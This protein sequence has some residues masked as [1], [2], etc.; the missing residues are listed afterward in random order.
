MLRVFWAIS[1]VSATV[2]WAQ[3][4]KA[5]VYV[6]HDFTAPTTGTLATVAP[7]TDELG[8]GWLG[9]AANFAFTAGNQGLEC[10]ATGNNQASM[11]ETNGREDVEVT[12][13][14]TINKGDIN[15]NWQGV[16]LRGSV[17]DESG[18]IARFSGPATDPDLLL[19][20]GKD[21]LL[22][23]WD[24]SALLTTQPLSGDTVKLV[25]RCE[26]DAITFQSIQVNAGSVET[27]ASAYTLLGTSQI[28]HGAGSG[29]DRYGLLNKERLAS[30]VERYTY[31]K[32]ASIPTGPASYNSYIALDGVDDYISTPDS[33]TN[34]VTGD[35]DI[36]A[37]VA[38]D[39]ST[40]GDEII[41]GKDV[42]TGNQRSI[43]LYVSSTKKLGLQPSQDGSG[44]FAEVSSVALDVA[45]NEELWIRGT[46]DFA[47]GNVTFYTATDEG[48]PSS[49]SQLGAVQNT[50]LTAIYDSSQPWEIGSWTNGTKNH[51]DGKIYYAEVRDGIGGPVVA[52]F[53]ASEGTD[54]TYDN[55]GS[56]AAWTNYGGTPGVNP[57][58]NSPPSVTPVG[59][60]VGEDD[61][62]LLTGDATPATDADGDPITVSGIDGGLVGS[63]VAGTYGSLTISADG[64]Y[65][66]DLA[67]GTP[68]VDAIRAG[69]SPQDA[70][71]FHVSAGVN[72]AVPASF[73]VT[74]TGVN[75]VPTLDNPITSIPGATVG[76]ARYG[77]ALLSDQF[78]D[79][80]TAFTYNL[81]GIKPAWLGFDAATGVFSLLTPP[82]PAGSE[83][84]Y[85]MS[86]SVTDLD[87]GTS[88]PLDD[89]TFTVAAAG[90]VG[91]DA[92]VSL[93]SVAAPGGSRIDLSG[94]DLVIENRENAYIRVRNN[95]TEAFVIDPS[96]NFGL[97]ASS[98]SL[99]L[100]IAGDASSDIL[101]DRT[102]NLN[103]NSTARLGV[104]YL[105][106]LTDEYVFLGGGATLNNLAVQLDTG[107]VGIGTTTFAHKL[108]VA[109][110]IRAHELIVDSTWADHVFEDGYELPTLEEVQAHIEEKGHLPGV[111]S[112]ESIQTDGLSLGESQ[113]LLMQKIE[114]LTL[115]I[116]EQDK[117]LDEKDELIDSLMSRIQK[118]EE[119]KN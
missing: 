72:P 9:D 35:I 16:F 117:R 67:D 81:T 114:E 2:H 63:P 48:Y 79:K 45:S 53:N 62:L 76:D 96:G 59:L 69:Q 36:I 116:L 93:T 39:W 78:S 44:S 73:T 41:V 19:Y 56:E 23:T 118:L 92:P 70:F 61:N 50:T 94:T 102:Q 3:T 83:G 65:S 109:G 1:V 58:A 20:D 90:G 42:Q 110:T 68:A 103:V 14:M 77:H 75:D 87:A 12:L 6:E 34:S 26:G 84:V 113:A 64:T 95:A 54:P 15:T 27:V 37:K 98:P 31:F 43:L 28:D 17:T 55:I 7:Q 57:P 115:Y 85:A 71:T 18:M 106:G 25:M 105:N 10:V 104:S 21:L 33:V 22:H 8:G 4:S 46:I 32:V 51:F 11:V 38:F 100:H 108:N 97:G 89:F 86:L 24:L 82:V 74:V 111:P 91:A 60:N 99:N 101:L 119:L 30:S 66:Y 80:E 88:S 40:L 52:R 29:K 107:N 112:A 5:A 13:E 47:T 49:W